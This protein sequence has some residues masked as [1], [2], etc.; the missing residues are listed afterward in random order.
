MVN[1]MAE[2][3]DRAVMLGKRPIL[4]YLGDLDPSGIAIPKALQRN[5]ADWHSVDVELVRV[6]LN[7]TQVEQYRLPLSPDAA[8]ETDPNYSAWLAEYGDQVPVELDALHPRDLTRITKDALASIYDMTSVDA[9]KAKEAEER[10]LL[11]QMKRRVEDFIA[12]EWPE[13]FHAA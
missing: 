12:G 3:F 7:P 10:D 11:R 1:A 9:H 6:A 5:M 4:L 2:R 13:V 8:K